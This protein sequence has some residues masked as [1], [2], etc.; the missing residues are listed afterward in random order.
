MTAKARRVVTGL[1]GYA[2]L[3]GLAWW[4]P[5]TPGELAWGLWI[6]GLVVLEL[7]VVVMAGL[8]VKEARYNPGMA[9]AMLLWIGVLGWVLVWVYGLYGEML[10]LGFPLVPD[11]G[12]VHVGGTTWKNVRPFEFWPAARLAL[13]EFYAVIAVTLVPVVTGLKKEH[14]T[15]KAFRRAPGFDGGSIIRL[16]LTVMALVLLQIALQGQTQ[17]YAFLL[18][19]VIL[20]INFFPREIVG[21]E[22]SAR[23]AAT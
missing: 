10:D 17:R 21:G 1:A 11:P 2:L 22:G 9:V 19:A 13:R 4:V 7:W 20:T 5:W 14:L 8:R 18:S 16:H 15:V 12:R 6:S 3:L 23:A